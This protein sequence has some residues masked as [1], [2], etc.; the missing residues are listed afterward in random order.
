METEPDV[1]GDSDLEQNFA[2]MNGMLPVISA[3]LEN[4]PTPTHDEL[5]MIAFAASRTSLRWVLWRLSL[6]AQM[7][8]ETDRL[9]ATAKIGALAT[10]RASFSRDIAVVSDKLRTDGDPLSWEFR[11]ALQKALPLIRRNLY[12]DGQII[13]QGMDGRCDPGLWGGGIPFA[14]AT[15]SDP[16]P[17][18]SVCASWFPMNAD[19]HR[20]VITHEFFHLI[21]LI[22]Q[23]IIANSWDALNDANTMAQLV[24][25][26]YDRRRWEDSSGLSKP[27]A[28]YPAP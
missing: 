2:Q 6:L 25:Y 7:I 17:R 9:H 11:S 1:Y 15:P 27:T 16:E 19:L 13:D 22:D 20:D 28:L 10:L 24:A 21:G 23:R 18:I 12:E 3:A 4:P 5:I 26:I 14:A 8:E